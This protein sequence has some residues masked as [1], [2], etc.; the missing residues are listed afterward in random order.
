MGEYP[1]LR[2]R[3]GLGAFHD[4]CHVPADV[5]STSE[6]VECTDH[7]ARL[8]LKHG[9]RERV[10]LTNTYPLCTLVKAAQRPLERLVIR[11]YEAEWGAGRCSSHANHAPD[12]V[13]AHLKI[14]ARAIQETQR[15]WNELLRKR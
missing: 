12:I 1:R 9:E 3:G 10:D 13:L 8:K 2:V 14:M 4:Q 7:L 5:I 11:S 6:L 15:S